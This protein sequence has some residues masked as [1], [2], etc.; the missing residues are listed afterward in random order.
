MKGSDS[1]DA[2]FRDLVVRVD[3]LDLKLLMLSD[4][5][6]MVLELALE[7]FRKNGRDK[8]VKKALVGRDDMRDWVK[9]SRKLVELFKVSKGAVDELMVKGGESY[10]IGYAE[11]LEVF[12][13]YL[14]ICERWCM[15]FEWTMLEAN[16]ELRDGIDE[17]LRNE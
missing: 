13:E 10:G 3:L 14:S 12:S 5:G 16:K 1:V 4:K 2:R 11:L 8:L 6:E 9:E 15:E 7:R 17:K